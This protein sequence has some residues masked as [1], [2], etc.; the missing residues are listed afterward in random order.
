MELSLFMSVAQSI[1]DTMLQND[2]FL[3]D[4]SI[5]T[6]LPV[7][8]F[9]YSTVCACNFNFGYGVQREWNVTEIQ[10]KKAYFWIKRDVPR[11]TKTECGIRN[12]LG[13]F[14]KKNMKKR[15]KENKRKTRGVKGEGT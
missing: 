13:M 5:E 3:S 12:R 14:W 10:K 9:K 15:Q 1:C 2:F 8:N 7:R 4:R 6:H 11:K